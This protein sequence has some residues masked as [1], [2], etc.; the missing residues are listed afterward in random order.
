MSLYLRKYLLSKNGR[1]VYEASRPCTSFSRGDENVSQSSVAPSFCI[2]ARDSVYLTTKKHLQEL[3]AAY[4]QL[5]RLTSSATVYPIANTVL[6]HCD[7]Q[8]LPIS[9]S[10][11]VNAIPLSLQR[12]CVHTETVHTETVHFNCLDHDRQTTTT[13][14]RPIYVI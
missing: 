6:Y 9:I 3:N 11:S 10:M 12:N 2:V 1:M 4:S 5:F 8:C 13:Y 14:T 7:S